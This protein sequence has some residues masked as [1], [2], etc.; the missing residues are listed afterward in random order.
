VPLA[1]YVHKRGVLLDKAAVLHYAR[2]R[3]LD[4]RWVGCECC[5]TIVHDVLVACTSIYRQGEKSESEFLIPSIP[6]E[7]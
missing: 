2:I 5:F 3:S 1:R 6:G 7:I 4:D